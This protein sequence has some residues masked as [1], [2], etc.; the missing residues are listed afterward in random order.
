MVNLLELCKES[1]ETVPAVMEGPNSDW[2]PV[3]MYE[4]GEGRFHTAA[5]PGMTSANVTMAAKTVERLLRE[6]GAVQASL[7]LPTWFNEFDNPDAGRIERV[8]VTHVDRDDTTC[9]AARV[10]RSDTEK[11]RLGR[12]DIYLRDSDVGGGVFVD[13]MRAAIG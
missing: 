4:D 12:W 3:L 10:I 8:L 5:I 11:P 2:T 13:A 6:A 9:E 1:A 7:V